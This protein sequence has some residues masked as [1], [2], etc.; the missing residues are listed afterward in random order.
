MN[1]SFCIVIYVDASQVFVSLAIWSHLFF[2]LLSIETGD[3]ISKRV[4]KAPT[5]AWVSFPRK[6]LIARR[7]VQK[8]NKW[9]ESNGSRSWMKKLRDHWLKVGKSKASLYLYVIQG[10]K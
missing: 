3:G 8:D 4:D 7:E 6:N 5:M 10:L 1:T 2:L 9:R